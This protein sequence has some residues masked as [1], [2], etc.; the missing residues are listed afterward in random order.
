MTMLQIREAI[1]P[2]WPSGQTTPTL[3]QLRLIYHG[4]FLTDDKMLKDLPKVSA[5]ETV[6]MHVHVK[7]LDAKAADAPS[8]SDDKTPKCSCIIS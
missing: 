6:A 4:K 7:M 2:Q 5:G 3:P 8:N 1:L